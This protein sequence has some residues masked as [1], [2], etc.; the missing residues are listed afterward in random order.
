MAWKIHARA[1][2]FSPSPSMGEGGSGGASHGIVLVLVSGVL[3]AISLLAAFSLSLARHA[4][5]GAEGRLVARSAE[6]AAQSALQYAA[7][8]LMQD[9]IPRYPTL[10]S[11]RGDD[12]RCRGGIDP[13][14]AG[15]NPS[16]SHGDAWSDQGAPGDGVYTAGYDVFDPALHDRDGDGRFSAR[17]GRLRNDLSFTLTVEAPGGKIPLNAGI[18]VASGLG[19]DGI[20][21]NLNGVIDEDGRDDR[22]DNDGDGQSDEA[23]EQA[24]GE[25]E[26][27]PTPGETP[28]WQKRA[29]FNEAVA[30]ALDSLGVVLDIQG[31][32][33][34]ETFQGEAF[35][36]STLGDLI[37]QAPKE[38][39]RNWRSV[40]KALNRLNQ[41]GGLPPYTQADSERIRPFIDLGPYDRGGR[42]GIGASGVEFIGFEVPIEF[43]TASPEVLKALWMHR[44][45]DTL[46]PGDGAP[47]PLCDALPGG[48][49][50]DAI[51]PH[52]GVS[53]RQTRPTVYREEAERLVE[54]AIEAREAGGGSWKGLR[55]L[56]LQPATIGDVF[57]TELAPLP[58]A[59]AASWGL[60]KARLAIAA[61][62]GADGNHPAS[63]WGAWASGQAG[64][65]SPSISTLL[66]FR[67]TM[68]PPVQFDVRGTGETEAGG[69]ASAEGRLRVAER[70]EL[71]T[72]E[73]FEN[74]LHGQGRR[75]DVLDDADAALIERLDMRVNGALPVTGDVPVYPDGAPRRYPH[76][77]AH[78]AGKSGGGTVVPL[79]FLGSGAITLAGLETGNPNDMARLYDA[80]T[81]WPSLEDIS[82][83]PPWGGGESPM[84]LPPGTEPFAL[85]A[86]TSG[87]ILE[88]WA[89]GWH[90]AGRSFA[91]ESGPSR[92]EILSRRGLDAADRPGVFFRL[93]GTWLNEANLY[94]ALDTANQ[95]AEVF[96]PDGGVETGF[97]R[98][99]LHFVKEGVQPKKTDIT[100][101]VKGIGSQASCQVVFPNTRVND[102]DPP[103]PPGFGDPPLLPG[104]N[105]SNNGIMRVKASENLTID[106]GGGWGPDEAL[107]APAP[108]VA[109]LFSEGRFLNPAY[110]GSPFVYR[111]PVYFA[112]VPVRLLHAGWDGIEIPG[113]SMRVMVEGRD[114]S[115]GTW[116]ATLPGL[117]SGQGKGSALPAS[118]PMKRF[119]FQVAFESSVSGPLYDTPVLDSL[120]LTY[121]R[122]GGPVWSDSR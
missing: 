110:G 14:A 53:Y 119:R 62:A 29:G 88:G 106:I 42:R 82:L 65:Y 7:A 18:E 8:R 101:A 63:F 45:G 73:D 93:E 102:T 77:C 117:A 114:V 72:R 80:Q 87:H 27:N 6:I 67:L 46:V 54:K 113:L 20:D 4:S 10:P 66:G 98:V 40:E 34:P 39:F 33:R 25:C 70:M 61:V 91:V 23:D 48:A 83:L 26:W 122:P 121:R 2:R 79:N 97:Y 30:R 99:S 118:E 112:D 120:W 68:A 86:G 16:W 57:G 38:G 105:G 12:W 74:H 92:I 71:T 19:K 69:T 49:A 17:S 75:I 24:F 81:E 9:P 58:F 3:V 109:D 50:W 90:V 64:I 15:L 35:M 56:L 89:E 115:N 111:S 1:P 76:L 107:A 31:G 11:E 100:L 37:T 96:I 28:D 104:Q 52:S 85:S 47:I 22:I 108:I 84:S 94:V 55:D 43:L 32:R 21:N 51:S 59:A 36:A 44:L 95:N 41:I 60:L 5:A 116:L 78:P 103:P 13:V